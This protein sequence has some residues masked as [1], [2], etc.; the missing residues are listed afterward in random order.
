MT[1]DEYIEEVRAIVA[2]DGLKGFIAQVWPLVAGDRE[3]YLSNWHIDAICE[4]LDGV[5]AGHIKRLAIAVPARHG[6]STV[7]RGAWPAYDWIK[8]PAR[9]FIQAYS[10]DHEYGRAMAARRLLESDSYRACWGHTHD[11]TGLFGDN[12]DKGGFLKGAKVGSPLAGEAGDFLIGDTLINAINVWSDKQR[13]Q[14]MKWW[15]EVM[16][17]RLADPVNGAMVVVQTRSHH[18]DLIGHVMS[19]APG[20][21]TYLC[22]PAEYEPDHPHR[23]VRDPR[24]EA[25]ELLWPERFPRE[26]VDTLKAALGP[27][28]SAAQLQQR[29]HPHPKVLSVA[30]GGNGE[31]SLAWR[32]PDHHAGC[33]ISEHL[34]D[35]CTCGV[36]RSRRQ[37]NAPKAIDPTTP[38]DVASCGTCF[39][40]SEDDDGDGHGCCALALN[41]PTSRGWRTRPTDSCTDWTG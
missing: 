18:D 21:W 34:G 13:T 31:A 5:S 7:V 30:L 29:P 4:H 22:L 37:E 12:N 17:T 6:L 11:L 40:F 25:G 39:Y 35:V 23:W 10:S 32:V 1:E 33:A 38:N 19:K 26:D 3:P 9:R 27:A 16:T 14:V 15:D 41:D 2:K 28:A 24:K 8:H 20:D 36:T